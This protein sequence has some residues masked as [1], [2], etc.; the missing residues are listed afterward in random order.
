MF[1]S[2]R[3]SHDNFEVYRMRMNGTEQVRM[4]RTTNGIDDNAP[5]YAP[6]GRASSSPAPAAA[7]STTCSP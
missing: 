3:P 5:E 1:S 4:T 2:D 6:D 7:T